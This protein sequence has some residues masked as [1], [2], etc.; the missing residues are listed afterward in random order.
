MALV[1]RVKLKVCPF[2]KNSFW[3]SIKCDSKC[4]YSGN[5]FEPFTALLCPSKKLCG[6]GFKLFKMVRN[7]F[8]LHIIF[9]CPSSEPWEHI[10][11]CRSTW[12]RDKHKSCLFTA[13]QALVYGCVSLKG[14][15]A[16]P[17]LLNMLAWP[18]SKYYFSMFLFKIAIRFYQTNSISLCTIFKKR[19]PQFL[20]P[21]AGTNYP[22]Q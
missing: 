9:A 7:C 22:S 14:E 18:C 4:I 8:V 13:F 12:L 11:L 20:V 1:L 16:F 3:L 10:C 5:C 2:I 21:P 6:C 15:P 17:D 19:A